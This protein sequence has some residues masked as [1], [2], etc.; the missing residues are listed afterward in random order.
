MKLKSFTAALLTTCTALFS[1]ISWAEPPTE[2][3]MRDFQQITGNSFQK[4]TG[5]TQTGTLL[6]DQ[7]LPAL[8]ETYPDV[9]NTFWAEFL[10]E[11][12]P[13]EFDAA[14]LEIY[15]KYYSEEDMQ[16][17]IAFYKSELGKKMLAKTPEITLKASEA[18]QEWG[19]N[20]LNRA[21]EKLKEAKLI[22]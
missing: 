4:I 10:K 12:K 14:I 3:T 22:S 17:S 9:P 15:K 13:E 2:K 11:M 8:K 5:V 16:G 18:S 21:R 19:L 7:T 1:Q 6:I 20:T